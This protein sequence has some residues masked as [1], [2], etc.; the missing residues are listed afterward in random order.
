M[1]LIELM[2]KRERSG[3]YDAE[4]NNS[5]YTSKLKPVMALQKRNHRAPVFLIN[6][7]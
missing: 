2:I 1:T 6:N 7:V 3:G 4:G 5:Y